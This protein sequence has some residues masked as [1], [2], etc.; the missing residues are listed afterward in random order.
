MY[1]TSTAI[2]SNATYH[3]RDRPS[4]VYTTQC[5]SDGVWEP[6][7]NSTL[8]CITSGTGIMT[9]VMPNIQFNYCSDWAFINLYLFVVTW[10][11]LVVPT[12]IMIFAVI[13]TITIVFVIFLRRGNKSEYNYVV[14]FLKQNNIYKECWSL[15][16]YNIYTLYN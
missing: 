1:L 2:G 10:I 13:T 7:P 5:T 4:D 3:C 14:H 16:R 15:L 6:N 8:D 9:T 11:S 12:G